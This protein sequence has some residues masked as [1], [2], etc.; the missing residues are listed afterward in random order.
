MSLIETAKAVY[1]LAKKGMS[2]ELKEKLTQ[3]REEALE[4]QEENLNLKNEYLLLKGKN[5]I[6]KQLKFKRKV[7]FRDGDDTP[8]CPFCVERFG[9]VF[10]LTGPED[11]LEGEYLYRCHTCEKRYVAS[12]EGDFTVLA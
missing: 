6:Q 3:L 10:H 12:G 11:W 2:T 5:D 1:D 9:R 4:L 7:Y 8:F